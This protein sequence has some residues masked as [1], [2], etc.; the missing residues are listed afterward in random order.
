MHAG[1]IFQVNAQNRCAV[2]LDPDNC[3]RPSCKQTC[4]TQYKGIGIC[5][6]TISGQSYRCRCLYD[7]EI[8]LSPM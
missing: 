6:G 8:E 5:I 7:C 1:I 2:T 4:F 3:D